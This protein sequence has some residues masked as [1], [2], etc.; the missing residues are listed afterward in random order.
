MTLGVAALVAAAPASAQVKV[1]TSPTAISARECSPT[2]GVQF[3]LSRTATGPVRVNYT[4]QNLTA[5]AGSDYTATT[6]FRNIPR[7]STTTTLGIPILNNS[8]FEP[9]ENFLIRITSVSGGG[10]T[11]DASKSQSTITIGDDEIPPGSLVG[12]LGNGSSL[13]TAVGGVETFSTIDFLTANGYNNSVS[14]GGSLDVNGRPTCTTAPL[15]R[16]NFREPATWP[17]ASATGSTPLNVPPAILVNTSYSGAFDPSQSRS[18]HWD[19]GWTVGVN[20]NDDVWRFFGGTLTTGTALTGKTPATQV[21]N[22]TCPAGTTPSGT[23]AS[24]IGNTLNDEEGLFTAA[25]NYDICKLPRERLTNLALT[26]DN[27]YEL[28]DGFPGSYI[29]NGYKARTVVPTPTAVALNIQAGTLIFGEATEALV[30]GRGSDIFSRGTAVAP[31][32]MTSLRQLQQRFDANGATPVDSGSGEWAGLAILGNARDN[33]CAGANFA[34]CDQPLEGNIGFYGGNND[35]DGSGEVR[36][37]VI[38]HAGND[39]DGNG[40]ELNGF[41]MG[42][43]G[44]G[45]I[46]DYVQVHKGFDDGVEFFGGNAFIAH[47][48]ISSTFD[49]AFDYDNGFTG[50]A[51]FV[52]IVQADSATP[53]LGRGIEAGSSPG[54]AAAPFETFGLLANFTVVGPSNRISGGAIDDGQAVVFRGGVRTQLWNSVFAGDQPKGCLD[55]DDALTFTRSTEA[56]GTVAAPGPNLSVRNSIFDCTAVSTVESD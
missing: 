23:F 9:N 12:T 5:T 22:G 41:T 36:Y 46:L 6:G 48:V 50:G 24:R 10:A 52:Y 54:N 4:T 40:N 30:I 56:G 53:G 16:G 45:T 26:N 17:P 49:D 55:I 39:I 8:P 28:A 31:I 27:V 37:T 2:A 47:V 42:G 3:K 25:V 1:S 29:G 32:V 43:T 38:R 7:G 34:A 13:P 15:G 11:V 20:G 14:L 35:S 18:Q 19:Q 33:K 21:A 44:R 51:Q